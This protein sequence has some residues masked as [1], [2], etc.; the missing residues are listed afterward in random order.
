MTG[1]DPALRWATL[2]LV[3]LTAVWG[4]TFFLIRD[5]V[6]TLPSADFLAVRFTIAALAMA[7]VF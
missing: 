7:L 4:S 1:R 3:A 6:R 5:L 2:A